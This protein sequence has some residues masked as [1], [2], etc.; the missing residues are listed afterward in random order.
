MYFNNDPLSQRSACKS[1]AKKTQNNCSEGSVSV[2]TD[3]KKW[4]VDIQE[5]NSLG[6]SSS[7]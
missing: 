6:I 7:T 5:L 1:Q 4:H 2:E 3:W